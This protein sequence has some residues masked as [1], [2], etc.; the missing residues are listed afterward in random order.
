MK[1][2]PDLPRRLLRAFTSAS[3]ANSAVEFA[4]LAPFFL[5]FLLGMIAY[6]LLLG[7]SH[8][9]QQIA[10]DAAR[11]SVAGLDSSERAE[12]ARDFVSRHA[13]GYAFVTLE[14]LSVETSE[15]AE[16]R[17]FTIAVHYDASRLPVWSLFSGLP[18]PHPVIVRSSTILRGG[19]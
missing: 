1:A 15:D 16:R 14:R 9:V 8:S 11:I 5:L 12:L 6:G 13:G 19:T 18:L 10:A 3:S 4:L 17:Q 7:A 2:A